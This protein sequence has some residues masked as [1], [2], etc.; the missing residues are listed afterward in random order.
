M[1]NLTQQSLAALRQHIDAIDTHILNLISERAQ[2][3]GQIGQLKEGVLYRPER[4]AQVLR[5]LKELNPGPLSDDAILFIFRELM[6]A[7]LAHERPVRVAYLG[8]QGTYSEAALLK[9]FGHAALREENLSLD[10]VFQSVVTQRTDFAIVPIENSIEGAVGRTLDLLV[11]MPVHVCGEVALRI[12]HQLMAPRGV[13]LTDIQ[14]VYSHPQSQAQCRAWLA[15][16]LP[17]V[18]L[19]PVASN[20]EAAKMVREK[21]HAA[22]IAGDIAATLYDLD[23]LAHNIEDSGNNTTRFFVMGNHQS[24]P[25]GHDKTSLLLV[26]KNRPGAIHELL[27]PLAQHGVSMTRLESRPA[28]TKLWEYVFFIDLMGHCEDPLVKLALEEIKEKALVCRVL[29]SYPVAPI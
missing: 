29:G 28:Q 9:H 20:A 11:E 18:S 8:P 22:A 7:C 5:R 6:S 1:V 14:E 26:A 27:T 24:T 23:I 10:D 21:T 2:L 12:H 16:H 25:S 19:I 3:A 4:E 17:K 15:A 13:P